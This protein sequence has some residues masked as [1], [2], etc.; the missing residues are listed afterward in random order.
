M[1]F[2]RTHLELAGI[3]PATDKSGRLVLEFAPNRFKHD[4]GLRISCSGVRH[5]SVD[6]HHAIDWMRVETVLLDEI[7]PDGHG[8]ADGAGDGGRVHEIALTDASITVRCQD[9][10]AEWDGGS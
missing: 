6:H 5:F 4:V 8:D 10:H 2:V 9:L 3:H 7:L 1:G